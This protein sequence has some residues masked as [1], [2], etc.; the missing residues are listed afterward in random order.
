MKKVRGTESTKVKM[1]DRGHIQQ[2]LDRS[3]MV[4][5][6]FSS[7]RNAKNVLLWV[8]LFKF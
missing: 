2:V 3:G 4:L 1:S 5:N 8:P 7:A 6:R